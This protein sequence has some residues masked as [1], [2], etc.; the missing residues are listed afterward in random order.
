MVKRIAVHICA[1]CKLWWH[2]III[3]IPDI[4]TEY[5]PVPSSMHA[6]Y[7]LGGG[8]NRMHQ[9]TIATCPFSVCQQRVSSRFHQ[10]ISSMANMGR[11]SPHIQ[12]LLQQTNVEPK[13]A[14]LQN[15]VGRSMAFW[16]VLPT[17][18]ME[19]MDGEMGLE[20]LQMFIV[21]ISTSI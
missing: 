21:T 15:S 6:S 5:I 3:W 14:S 16:K 4:P 10:G 17:P 7:V 2:C 20:S 1:I 19:W 9:I 13:G 8:A 18:H 11:H 12:H